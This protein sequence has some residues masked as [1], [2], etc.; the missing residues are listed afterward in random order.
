[1][2]PM[3]ELTPPDEAHRLVAEWTRA[4]FDEFLR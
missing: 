2:L 3:S 4:H 1:M